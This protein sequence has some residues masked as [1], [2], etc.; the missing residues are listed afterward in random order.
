[1]TSCFCFFISFLLGTISNAMANNCTL[2]PSDL[3]NCAQKQGVVR[4]PDDGAGYG[5]G[6]GSV[7][8]VENMCRTKW[9]LNVYACAHQ[10][11]VN[12]CATNAESH[13]RMR[14]W[15]FIFDASRYTRAAHYLCRLHNLS[16]FRMHRDSCLLPYE[17]QVNACSE[18]YTSLLAATT[19]RLAVN[20]PSNL[21]NEWA[22]ADYMIQELTRTYCLTTLS[23]ST[24]SSEF[25]KLPL[26]QL[27]LSS[28]LTRFIPL[29]GIKE[30]IQCV[31]AR[32]KEPCTEDVISLVRNY[33]R[34]T[35]P[36][37][38]PTQAEEKT[39][40]F[41]PVKRTTSGTSN[42]NKKIF[43]NS[44]LSKTSPSKGKSCRFSINYRRY[45]FI[46]LISVILKD[47]LQIC[48]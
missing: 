17:Q 16:I 12:R 47:T 34:E 24:G 4:F 30:K 48:I 28:P 39:Q 41:G 15:Q 9:H 37:N 32:L 19:L 45:F 10:T 14:M 22:Y 11:V 2:L 6:F 44:Y 1:M 23:L 31:T 40:I 13:F 36:E 3:L 7:L 5:F 29:R 42:P 27:V 8:D 43:Q 18:A 25:N 21:T 26:P 46:G 35:L 38:C 20:N 33:Y